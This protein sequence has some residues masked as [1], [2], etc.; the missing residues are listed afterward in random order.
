MIIVYHDFDEF[1]LSRSLAM[2]CVGVC[3]TF[4]EWAHPFGWN[5]VLSEFL[6][7][8]VCLLLYDLNY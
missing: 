6:L 2:G 5:F 8:G 4:E 7:F 1:P 3:L